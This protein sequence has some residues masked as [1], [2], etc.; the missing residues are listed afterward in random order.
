M[1]RE[2]F[3]F[4][5]GIQLRQPL[6]WVCA[7]IFGALAFGATTTDAIQVGGAIGN[8]N[9]NAPV[10]VAQLLGVFSLMSM[11]VVTIFI[12]GSVLRDADV[13]I[14]DMLFATPMKKHDYLVGRFAAGMVACLAIFGVIVLGMMLGPRMPWVDPQRVGPFAGHA[15]LWALGVLVMPNLLFIGALLMLLASTTSTIM[16]VYVGELGVFVLWIVAG[17]FTQNI[18]NEWIAV[19]ADPFGLRALAR[20]TRYFSTAE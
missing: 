17:R 10:V 12:A 11:F 18:D 9:R 3:K 8:V 20:A 1:L 7:L 16:L 14:S 19:L 4:E 15:Y 13:G 5:L 6:L 2:F